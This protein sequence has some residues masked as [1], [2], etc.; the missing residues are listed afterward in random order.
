MTH[1]HD[2]FLYEK[3]GYLHFGC[4][5]PFCGHGNPAL[6]NHYK[7]PLDSEDVV[8]RLVKHEAGKLEIE[9][10]AKVKDPEYASTLL[11][12]DDNFEACGQ[13]FKRLVFTEK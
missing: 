9:V 6:P 8:M 1:E 2:R 13:A 5:N 11:Q 7:V 3:D 4:I 10:T 12:S